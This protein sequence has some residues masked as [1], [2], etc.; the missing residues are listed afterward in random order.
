MKPNVIVLH[1][2]EGSSFPSYGGGGSA[3]NFTVK[4]T[5]VRQHFDAN[6]SSRALVNKSG[7]VAT[8]TLN[9]VQI[10]LVGTC[11]KGG[12]GL[13]WPNAT[14]ADMKGLVDLV[15]WLTT[16]YPGIPLVATLKPWLAYPASYGSKNKQRMTFAEW[17]K[18]RGIC[19]HQ[20]VP[21]N[22][23]GDPGN[24]PISRLIALVKS[25]GGSSS[26]S[27][28]GSSGSKIVSLNSAVKPGAT[29]TQVAELQQLLIKAGYGPIKGAV[30]KFY[31]TE[32][33]KAVARFH[34]RNPAY[35]SGLHDPRIGPKG[36]I[37][38]QKQ[39]GRR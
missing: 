24:F 14:D 13:Y 33:Q 21:E 27:S 39:A 26:G 6:E 3:P 4:G 28:S 36:F 9:V 23:H 20:H 11:V 31:G 32:T 37:A 29:H 10:E 15:K 34:D 38:L 7:G 22:D 8:N 1:T 17:N 18:F 35:R 30:T 25:A 2:T 16:T 19:G 12:P 5:T